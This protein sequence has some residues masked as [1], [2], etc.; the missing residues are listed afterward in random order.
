M[1]EKKNKGGLRVRKASSLPEG[2]P[3]PAQSLRSSPDPS[4]PPILRILRSSRSASTCPDP[5]D[6]PILRS[7][8]PPILR[9]SDPQVL[10]SSDPQ[11]LRSSGPQVLRSSDPQILRSSDPQI[12]RSSDPQILRSSGPQVLRSSDPQILR[13]SDRLDLSSTLSL[14]IPFLSSYSPPPILLLFS[15]Y[16]FLNTPIYLPYLPPSSFHVPLFLL[17]DWGSSGGCRPCEGDDTGRAHGRRHHGRGAGAREAA[18]DGRFEMEA[19][20]G[21][22]PTRGVR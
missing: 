21:S 7:S 16:T 3:L 9:S 10:R 17:L 22:C 1:R 13:S 11:V 8:D 4:G 2:L 12:L 15:T 14:P 6:P 5:S 18:G 19:G 20:R